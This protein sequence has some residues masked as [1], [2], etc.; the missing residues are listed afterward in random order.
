MD[1]KKIPLVVCLIGCRVGLYEGEV[2]FFCE[3]IN[4][5]V[6]KWWGILKCNNI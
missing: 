1:L 3:S 6:K 2:G 5:K 4:C